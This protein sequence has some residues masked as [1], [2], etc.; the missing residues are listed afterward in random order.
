MSSDLEIAKADT[1]RMKNAVQ[2]IENQV[3]A[4]V[5]KMPQ[6]KLLGQ[7]RIFQCS[8]TFTTLTFCKFVHEE[9]SNL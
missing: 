4:I 8:E 1:E 5:A 7:H 6:R 2:S 9:L 3:A